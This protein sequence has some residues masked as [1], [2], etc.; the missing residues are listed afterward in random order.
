MSKWG[1][2]TDC[3]A[4]PVVVDGDMTVSQSTASCLYLGNK[5]GLEPPGFN[6]YKATQHMIDIVDTFEGNLGKHNEHG[7]T[8]PTQRL[9]PHISTIVRLSLPVSPIHI[10]PCSRPSRAHS[11]KSFS[12]ASAGRCS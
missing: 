8:V 2:P 4:P 7:P 10:R 6:V 3:F 12:R 9:Q 5:L 1:A 11:S